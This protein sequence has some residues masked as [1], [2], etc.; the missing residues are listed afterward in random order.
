MG[1]STE[2]C[3]CLLFQLI[4]TPHLF[5]EEVPVVRITISEFIVE[6]ESPLSKE[7]TD[8]LLNPYLG[9]HEGLDGL[10]D[11]AA[12]LER[13][14][15][16]AGHS[17]HRVILPP[18]T[19]EE[20]S[21]RLEVVVYTLANVEIKGNQFFSDENIRRSLPGLESGTT[22][23]PPPINPISG[24][25]NSPENRVT[26]LQENQEQNQAETTYTFPEEDEDDDETNSLECR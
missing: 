26:V 23:P 15:L 17:F 10:L 21:V 4:I 2:K 20:G 18:Q 11:A 19:L 13:G 1:N 7:K 25:T 24:S 6:G 3:L 14:I 16:E 12:T 9:E 22:P 8:E 5:A